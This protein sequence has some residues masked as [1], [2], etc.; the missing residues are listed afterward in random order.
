MEEILYTLSVENYRWR[1][2]TIG[3]R[4]KTKFSTGKVNIREI[5]SLSKLVYRFDVI[6]IKTLAGFL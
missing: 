3:F 4:D 2:K 1:V 6:P 5:R